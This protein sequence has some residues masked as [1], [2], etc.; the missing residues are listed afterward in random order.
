[1]KLKRLLSLILTITIL[2]GS[3]VLNTAIYASSSDFKEL[4]L[5]MFS[6]T[7][8]QTTV[9][10]IYQDNVFYL[11][12][13]TLTEIAGVEILKDG[14]SESHITTNGGFRTFIIN[15]EKQMM[16]EEYA[17][18]FKLQI[19]VCR[20]QNNTYISAL[21]F[22]RY[23][24]A[25][26][27]IKKDCDIQFK[28]YY[29]YNIYD[30]LQD[31]SENIDAAYFHW[32]EI[33]HDQPELLDEVL[34]GSVIL[35]LLNKDSNFLRFFYDTEGLY[36]ECVEDALLSIVK[37]EG[38]EKSTNQDTTQNLIDE[39][40]WT[41]HLLSYGDKGTEYLS[42]LIEYAKNCFPDETL[43]VLAEYVDGVNGIVSNIGDYYEFMGAIITNTFRAQ[44][45]TN[46]TDTQKEIVGNTIVQNFDT[47]MTFLDDDSMKSV[48]GNASKQTH[49]RIT[50]AYVNNISS[51]RDVLK[52]LMI[53]KLGDKVDKITPIPIATVWNLSMDIVK[54]I[55]YT[56]NIMDRQSMVF[57]AYNCYILEN[58][59]NQVFINGCSEIVANKYYSNN[60]VE[61]ESQLR[62]IQKCLI[63]Q[64]KA[65]LTA[66][67][68]LLQSDYVLDKNIQIEKDRNLILVN[69][70]N[71]LHNCE[72]VFVGK[73]PN[74]TED[75]SWMSLGGDTSGGNTTDTTD[76][77]TTDVAGDNGDK[78]KED[79]NIPEIPV[80]EKYSEG[81]AFELALGNQYYVVTGI[82]S[83]SDKELS[84]P[85][86]HNGKPVKGIAK[87]A[88]Y[89]NKTITSIT[90]P[91][92]ISFIESYAFAHCTMLTTINY[93][94][95]YCEDLSK[96]ANGV[97]YDA[98]IDGTGITVNIG[99]NV[100]RIPSY[101]FYP[102]GRS[103]YS[104]Q[105][106]KIISVIF[107]KD[108]V[109]KE[110]G[111][112]AFSNCNTITNIEF[113]DDIVVLSYRAFAGCKISDLVL[114]PYLQVIEH[115]ALQY[116]T[117]S[118]IPPSLDSHPF[119]VE[120]LPELSITQ[121]EANGLKYISYS[122]G[123]CSVA[124]I[125]DT[126]VKNF[127]IPSK[128]PSGDTVIGINANAF[129]EMD[130]KSVVIP[131][132][133]QFIGE[134]AFD[135]TTAL[136]K[137]V[138]PDS[139]R[140]I[141]EWA[142]Y[143]SGIKEITLSKGIKYIGEYAFNHATVNDDYIPIEKV[144]FNGSVSDWCDIYFYSYNSNPCV[145]GGVLYING[146]LLESLI[147]PN[148]VLILNAH[149]F[150]GASSLK[151]AIIG[152]GVRLIGDESFSNCLNL[153][154]VTIGEK[155]NIIGEYAFG[156]CEKIVS[157][158]IPG[159]C[160][161]IS[162]GAFA[163]CINL[164]NVEIGEGISTIGSAVFS[165]CDIEKIRLFYKGDEE[166]WDKIKME[167]EKPED[168][169]Y[170]YSEQKPTDDGL[171][172]HYVNSIPTVWE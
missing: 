72:M 8:S 112:Y 111:A 169:L 26:V 127:I 9:S 103:G 115:Q 167:N 24:G 163:Y 141:G 49:S 105:S 44:Q 89:E 6:N 58:M 32:Y 152:N 135:K 30:A 132:T 137:I 40:E 11:S 146:E 172:W 64:Y 70:L 153:E 170:F 113:S 139:V 33:E 47:A 101:L 136:E 67:E 17:S 156:S 83:C 79:T 75:L 22:L 55:P 36:Q 12:L 94:A 109:C 53:N 93:N 143:E 124:A 84:I 27:E 37:N 131:D 66:R 96:E 51:V 52:N 171:Y 76:E 10:G 71:K 41:T 102:E 63:F 168:V 19:P 159:E 133:V 42:F 91:E 134:S 57:N 99:V 166:L 39:F 119:G 18:E 151:S 162:K 161:I 28:M 3:G 155:V 107:H 149:A 48:Y 123:T 117:P 158:C 16:Y 104:K 74:V 81:L 100:S 45:F 138:I 56:S 87:K 14:D 145:D 77:K 61:Q 165:D 23:I 31:Y 68:N 34:G 82:G 88:F 21:H 120:Y 142:F 130:I 78:T 50:S 85:N 92:N 46:I 69:L 95:I 13:D 150:Y 116:C 2:V 86:T 43:D 65:A 122:N 29:P 98:G 60:L 73:T 164:V 106:P 1:M 25:V 110:V 38:Q 140:T 80:V 160:R 59:V 5:S 20:Y 128:S 147:I 125:S 114:P 97:F 108:S 121:D 126:N 7:S 157:I 118:S 35:G 148:D 62:L 90:I 154:E 15:L 129:A 54:D 4:T 144:Y